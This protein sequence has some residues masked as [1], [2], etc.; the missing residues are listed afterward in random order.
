MKVP[1]SPS[2][3]LTTR[4]H[5]FGRR[6]RDERPLP[7]GRE[8]RPAQTAQVGLGNLIDHLFRGHRRENLPGRQVS[9]VRRVGFKPG[10][11]GIAEARREHRSVRAD[12][13]VR[14]RG[15]FGVARFGERVGEEGSD[16][17]TLEGPDKALVELGHGRHLAGAQAFDFR[18]RDRQAG[19]RLARA[20]LQTF[21]DLLHQIASAA[22][23]ARRTRAN[24][25]L[26]PAHRL[27]MEHVVEGDRLAHVGDRHSKFAPDPGLGVR[28][29]PALVFLDEPQQRQ[30]GGLRVLVA[31]Y[32]LVGFAFKV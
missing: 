23:H 3:A 18:E 6:L 29:D 27:G 11:V 26:A 32:N 8:S 9:V 14:F 7:A 25:E 24:P 17:L 31:P 19:S 10:S 1:G 30:H 5:R 21:L 2:S 22:Q 28:G 13:G 20:D 12:V 4:Y 16:G 15:R